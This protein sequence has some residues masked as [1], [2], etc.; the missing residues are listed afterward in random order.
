MKILNEDLHLDTFF[1][2]L[3]RVSNRALLLD[4]DGTLAPFRVERDE[5]TLYPGVREILG[6]LIDAKQL[7]V[8][9]ISGRAIEDLIPLLRLKQ[10]PEIWGSHGWERLLPDGRRLTADLSEPM[11]RVLVQ[12]PD[13]IEAVGLQSRYEPKPAG[14]ALHWRGTD[15]S[16]IRDIR[17]KTLQK[18]SSPSED[19]GLIAKEF[20][21]GIELSAAG[22]DKGDAARTIIS[23]MGEGATVA[24]LGD[25]LTD[26]DAFRVLKGKGLGVLVRPEFRP[27]TAD[28][29]L[30]PPDD[31]IE[32]LKNWI[33]ICRGN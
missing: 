1:D 10:L 20:D 18:W 2:K 24:Y 25:D 21:G 28:L 23:E 26:E 15:E 9:I 17:E 4:Y 14:F 16:V 6:A 27:T 7:R 33:T 5:A 19:S 30:Q 12:V 22:K 13:W 8:V 3:R 31:L 29:W 11:R 32:F